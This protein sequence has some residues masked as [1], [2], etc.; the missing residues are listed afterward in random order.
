MVN[1]NKKSKYRLI[2]KP[3]REGITDINFLG[4]S[5][6]IDQSNFLVTN[7]FDKVHFAVQ[8]PDELNLKE[9]IENCLINYGLKNICKIDYH[10]EFRMNEIDIVLDIDA[11]KSICK[12][13]TINEIQELYKLYYCWS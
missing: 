11:Y 13:Y 4:Y 6:T 12:S 10:S 3:Y 9:R 1:T 7:Y 2:G 8:S 5:G